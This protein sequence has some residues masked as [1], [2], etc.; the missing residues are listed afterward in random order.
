MARKQMKI[1]ARPKTGLA[2]VP[3]DSFRKCLF[4]FHYEIDS[5]E[6]SKIIKGHLKDAFAKDDYRAITAH[7][8]YNFTMASNYAAC[9]FW[10]KAGLKISDYADYINWKDRFIEHFSK[11]IETGKKL[12]LT[13]T[14]SKPIPVI[15]PRDRLIAKINSTIMVD[16]EDLEDDWMNGIKKT[17]DLYTQFKKYGLSGNA[18]D[19]VKEYIEFSYQEYSDA[20]TG[21]CDQAEEAWS[22][23]GKP[24]LKRRVKAYEEMLSDLD[25]I[26]NAA[27]AQRKTRVKKPRAADKQVDKIKFL[28]ESI[29]YK[30][31]SI[32]PIQIVGSMRLYVF[33]VK[34][35]ELTEYVSE[36]VT[37]FEVK[38]TTL[39]NV[40]EL[41]RKTR[42][43][44]PEDFLSIVQ[45]KTPRQV[46]NEWQ[47]L[48]TKTSS[49]NGRLN[50]D[51]LLLRVLDR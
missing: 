1:R 16:I 41:S 24:E 8:E 45:S 35:R 31:V 5:K 40:S 38:G 23:I 51:C 36:S 26:K 47:K 29:E 22:H 30:I 43:R 50:S 49:P 20:Y 39:Q 32:A 3:L 37:G 11:L 19:L 10:E 42:L 44:K 46:D 18:V 15:S 6:I 9:I 12:L 7:P 28:K 34:T 48:T 2:A 13:K 33:N 27:K 4:Y 14:V 17:I 21:A 25:K